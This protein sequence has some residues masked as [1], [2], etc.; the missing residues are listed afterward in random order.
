[1]HFNSLFF[2]YLS[3]PRFVLYTISI[4][5][6]Q[7]KMAMVSFSGKVVCN[8]FVPVIRSTLGLPISVILCMVIVEED[9][10]VADQF[11]CSRCCISNQ[12]CDECLDPHGFP[13]QRMGLSRESRPYL[14]VEDV[15]SCFLRW[16]HCAPFHPPG[17][18]RCSLL[19]CPSESGRA[20]IEFRRFNFNGFNGQWVLLGRRS[21]C[22]GEMALQELVGHEKMKLAKLWRAN[23]VQDTLSWRLNWGPLDYYTT[24]HYRTEVSLVF[25]RC[26]SKGKESHGYIL[27]WHFNREN[28]DGKQA[29][30]KKA[31]DK[32]LWFG[33]NQL[34]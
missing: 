13:G 25:F 30:K 2:I 21:G 32:F 4:I 3:D 24:P 1:M 29:P 22:G 16:C 27:G 19:L 5:H 20:R 31:H 28:E 7:K 17:D 34:K 9:Y 11:F 33:R 26:A 12:A 18:H 15:W 8:G 14:V 10:A 6:E 23:E